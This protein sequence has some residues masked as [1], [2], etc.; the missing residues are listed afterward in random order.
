MKNCIIV[1]ILFFI[2]YVPLVRVISPQLKIYFGTNFVV[3]VCLATLVGFVAP[4]IQI[5]YTALVVI[6]VSTV[7]S[8]QDVVCRYILLAAFLPP[9]MWNMSI[10]GHLIGIVDT[11]G[12][13]GLSALFCLNFFGKNSNNLPKSGLVA[14]DILIIVL[15]FIVSLASSGF[16]DLDIAARSV[17]QKLMLL[18]VPYLLLR[19]SL[20]NLS[21]YRIVVACFGISAVFLSVFAIYE[22]RH[23]WSIFQS[24]ESHM[25]VDLMT[26]NILVR[27]GL[28]RASATMA[29]PLGL[30]CYLT[31]GFFA[32][33]CS[34]DFFRTQLAYRACLGVTLVGLLA[35]QSR[36]SL[37]ALFASM[38][39]LSMAFRKWGMAAVAAALGGTVA[40]LL[41]FLQMMS[42]AVAGFMNAGGEKF[43]G[44]YFD[45]RGALLDHGLQ[46][47]ALHPIF[48]ER[49]DKVMVALADIVQGQHIIDLVNIYLVIL[50]VSGIVGLSLFLGLAVASGMRAAN[51]FKAIRDPSILRARAFCL[52]AFVVVLIQFSFVSFMDRI[53]MN[54]ALI[55]CGIR[56]LVM[57]R[58]SMR[59]PASRA[60]VA[61]ILSAPAGLT[62]YANDAMANLSSQPKDTRWVP[63][64][65][66]IRT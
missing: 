65:P 32:L 49:M 30:A 64:L 9:V 16:A 3:S 4:S 36:G 29:G 47:A 40:V 50:L 45:Y 31:V 54:L 59:R 52:A 14:E 46:E 17:T 39:V 11:S 43:Q 24:M 7:R 1:L 38:I 10:Q 27:G 22:A 37:I 56:L 19:Y 60:P 28:L 25:G 42:P 35:S 41:P 61:E 18:V 8:R 66:T 53:P 57:E 2:A 58:Q 12:I 15:F 62:A 20:I 33:A 48:G 21:Q 26:K 6:F 23:G 13:L 51:G 5:F 63:R 34:R 55:V 44:K